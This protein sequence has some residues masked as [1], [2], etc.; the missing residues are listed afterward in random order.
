LTPRVFRRRRVYGRLSSIKHI[1][2]VDGGP[3]R[4]MNT[5]ALCDA[6]AEGARAAS[7]EIEVEPLPLCTPVAYRA[8]A[9][10]FAAPSHGHEYVATPDDFRLFFTD[11][12][13]L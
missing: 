7:P 11:Y 9:R 13:A 1:L 8:G 4:A 3:R 5:A 12:A 10:V 2:I 6:F